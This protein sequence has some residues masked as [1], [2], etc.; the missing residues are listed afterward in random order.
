MQKPDYPKEGLWRTLA[1]YLK[2]D[3]GDYARTLA[4]TAAIVIVTVVSA[5]APQN[6]TSH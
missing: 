3:W 1:W 5:P 4:V 2:S 6:E